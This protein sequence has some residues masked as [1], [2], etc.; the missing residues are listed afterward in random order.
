MCSALL[1]TAGQN[2]DHVLQGA[3]GKHSSDSRRP[4]PG[5]TVEPEDAPRFLNCYC[6]GHCPEDAK[7]NTCM[8]VTATWLGGTKVLGGRKSAVIWTCLIML[9]DKWPVL[10]HYG[11]RWK[12][13]RV[14]E[15]WLHEVWRLSFSVQGK[16]AG[17]LLTGTVYLSTCKVSPWCI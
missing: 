11:R 1:P 15:L 14:L 2:P 13:R 17:C 6:S 7:N 10:C 4:A 3:G 12:W 16:A 9:Q 8:W 5:S